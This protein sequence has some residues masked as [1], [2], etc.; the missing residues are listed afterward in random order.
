MGN[1][2]SNCFQSPK[3]E[4]L[5]V[6]NIIKDLPC[7]ESKTTQKKSR[8]RKNKKQVLRSH[9]NEKIGE[10]ITAE[11]INR[12]KTKSD[13][14]MIESALDTHFILK[15]LDLDGK[16]I[17]IEKMKHYSIGAKEVIFHQ[18]NPADC[19]FVLAS[20]RLEVLVNEVRVNTINPGT[21]F[22]ELALIDNCARSATV[23]TLEKS[24]LWGLDRKTFKI[25]VESL[26]A[27][28]Y[29][30]N[31][32]F[33]ESVPIFQ[34]FTNTQKELLMF[35]MTTQLWL[36]G[37]KIVKEGDTGESFFIIKDGVVTCTQKG[38]ELRQMTKG[39]FFGEQALLNRCVRTATV[40]ALT[41][42]KILSIG[43]STILTVLGNSLEEVL[44]K[45]TI[46][47]S[48]EKSVVFSNCTGEQLNAIIEK[49]KIL[50]YENG[51]PVIMQGLI[52]GQYIW[53][54][55]KNKLRH[56]DGVIEPFT[57]IG[58][59]KLLVNSKEA[60]ECCYF[61][62]GLCVVAEISKKEIEEVLGDDIQAIVNQNSMLPTLR[63]IQIL[64][65]LGKTR[66]NSVLRAFKQVKFRAGE[67][68]FQQNAVGDKFYIIKS[69]AVDIVKDNLQVRSIN[70]YDY[71][72]ER[73]ILFNEVRSA[74]VVA[75]TDAVCWVLQ[76]KDFFSIIDENIRNQLQ[77]RIELQDD[78]ITLGDL[79]P[80]KLLGK[81]QF[82]CVYLVTHRSKNVQ[83]ALKTVTRQKIAGFD[84]YDNI[85]LERKILLQIDHGMIVKL[86]KTFKDNLRIYFLL[87]YVPGMDL[88]DV[89]TI[90]G[91]LSV[92]NT[93]FYTACL[94][95][96]IENLHKRGIVYRDLKPENIMVD[97]EGY[98]KLID[99]GTAKFIKGKTYTIVG[100]PHYMAPEVI[101]GSGYSQTVDL[102]S[103]G[104]IIYEFIEGNLPFGENEEDPY[105]IY[106]KVL[107]HKL[108][109]SELEFCEKLKYLVSHLLSVDPVYRGQKDLKKMR[110]LENYDWDKLISRELESPYRAK[111]GPIANEISRMKG[112]RKN[113]Q[114]FI[115]KEE[116]SEAP[117]RRSF[118]PPSSNWDLEF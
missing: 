83:Y 6:P 54:V 71:F 52:K 12:K 51:E 48:F 97:D 18:G 101:K 46:R 100:T 86:I 35:A 50:N 61:A 57:C 58:D 7:D 17:I 75:N 111:V 4:S 23:R 116:L 24:I 34:T 113:L 74:S 27:T 79:V 53:V 25:S 109:F 1:T 68:I 85:V 39:N 76:S 88:F 93:I 32:Q 37:E 87:E 8:K 49:M 5:N 42:A 16:S 33:L 112:L 2:C 10:A 47:M 80:I 102:W 44:Y 70:K 91:K 13:I 15:N 69:G 41:D 107:D 14:K 94:V 55:L 105:R 59:Q 60:F 106:E 114:E 63:N 31:L 118:K 62:D 104:V 43:R 81:G 38:I 26:N 82:G 56:D 36:A 40:T 115:Q 67:V 84:F 110:V 29:S 66:F 99:F 45:N 77:K 72:G 73:S 64:R 103:M 96:I 20:G 30:E 28:N 78:S 108:L 90:M 3:N 117:S 98:L 11:I 21:G 22:G 89:L 9:V 92:K 19:F 95:L 65:H